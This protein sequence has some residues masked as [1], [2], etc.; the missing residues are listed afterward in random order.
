MALLFNK[1]IC[2]KEINTTKKKSVFI[3]FN[4]SFSF[5][6]NDYRRP[7]YINFSPISKNHLYGVSSEIDISVII[8]FKKHT[9]L[10]GTKFWL[11][12]E[13]RFN[14]WK[15]KGFILSYKFNISDTTKR[16]RYNL[17]YDVMIAKFKLSYN[18]PP[19]NDCPYESILTKTILH[20]NNLV[21]FGVSYNI[22]K[23]LY[24]SS[25]IGIG[26]HLYQNTIV[27]EVSANPDY[28]VYSRDNLFSNGP[29]TSI[30]RINLNYKLC[31]V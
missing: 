3:G 15:K 9:F 25:E 28:D 4:S 23:Y 27:R 7:G 30:F 26:I 31:K 22:T 29:V 17:F 21:G 8:G 14:D 11:P 24:L 6:I 18:F 16:F 5:S 13:Y 1:A 10:L 2:Q 20:L 12:D 19:L